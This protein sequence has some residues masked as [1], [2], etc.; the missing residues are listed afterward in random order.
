MQCALASASRAQIHQTH[1]NLHFRVVLQFCDLLLNLTTR[2]S[3]CFPVA[4]IFAIFSIFAISRHTAVSYG[5]PDA[6]K[7]AISFPAQHAFPPQLG[8]V[9]QHQTGNGD[10]PGNAVTSPAPLFIQP[11]IRRH[12]YRCASSFNT[13]R[14]PKGDKS[15]HCLATPCFELQDINRI[16]DDVPP[17]CSFCTDPRRLLTLPYLRFSFTAF[18]EPPRVF[19]AHTHDSHSCRS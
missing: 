16:L 12:H 15:D 11:F 7:D 19:I 14:P 3:L 18:T 17:R 13:I 8:I 2:S 9:L 1:S 6:P 5:A 10:R 4:C